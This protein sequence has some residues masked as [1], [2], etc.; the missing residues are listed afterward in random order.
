[1]ILAA[2]RGQRMLPLSDKMPK[3]LLPVGG[4]PLI[5]WHVEN[6]ARAGFH[7]IVIN[8]AYLGSMIEAALGNGKRFSVRIRYSAE[9]EALET[10]GGIANAL[11]L[12]QENAFVVVNGD[13]YCD[14]DF[15]ALHPVARA[16][17]LDAANTLGHLVLVDNPPHHPHGDFSLN[18]NQVGGNAARLT[19]S[20]IAVYQAALFSSIVA[21]S[22]ASLA[23]LLHVAI[24][25]G[26][27]RGERF[28]G[29][30]IDVGTP[31][32][33]DEANR[34]YASRATHFFSSDRNRTP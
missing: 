17:A 21:G 27:I 3:A 20:G 11:P 19:F 1:M 32:R 29:A 14:Y 10:A 9:A 12:L 8:H 33:L 22:K 26:R 24:A 4:K 6:L 13:V 31:E 25:A 7:D 15:G 23:P 34:R 5:Q 28:E 30:W 16:L 18:H 2:G